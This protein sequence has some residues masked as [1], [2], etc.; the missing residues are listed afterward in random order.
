MKKIILAIGLAFSLSLS[1]Q[2]VDV[3]KDNILVDGSPVAKIENTKGIVKVSD[4][5]GKYLFSAERATSTLNKK[6]GDIA[7]W[8]R[9]TGANGNVREV[10]FSDT[11]FTLSNE[12]MITRNLATGNTAFLT[13]SG[14]NN[15]LINDYF[16][17]NEPSIS[18]AIEAQYK[19]IEE[20]QKAEDDKAQKA[21]LS[22]NDKGVIS[23][24]G[25]KAGLIN[26]SIK[27]SNGPVDPEYYTY[28]ATDVNGVV[29]AKL[30]GDALR[31]KSLLKAKSLTTYDGKT[32]DIHAIYSTAPAD[33][34]KVAERIVKALYSNGYNFGD[35]KE[36]VS[37][38]INQAN[39]DTYNNAEK[40]TVNLVNTDGYVTD[41]VGNKISGL[42]SIPFEN[43]AEKIKPNSGMS[44]ITNFGGFVKVK[45]TDGKEKSYKAK[46]GYTVFAGN[47]IFIPAKG[48]NDDALNSS[49]GSQL[50]L[51][52]EY[53]YFEKDYE[54][55][56]G[57]I[58]HH[59]K[60]P[61]YFYIKLK[62]SDI[63]SY[64]GEKGVFKNKP[65]EKMEKAFNETLKCSAM[66]FSDY[67]TNSK[68]GM[69]KVLE[70]YAAKCK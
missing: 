43:V 59:V 38:T 46:D 68:E 1:A 39:A 2:K 30:K 36:T 54:N 10:E 3:K 17:K 60:S 15:A 11:G 21:G 23:I 26:L 42:V 8:L 34:N 44:D 19:T 37:Q 31:G 22:I 27:K 49:S 40:N 12:K 61:N 7:Y 32:L 5:N 16:A 45:S 13:S 47:R 41:K 57:Y 50:S 56:A 58:V 65:A 64:L 53:Q 48:A 9:L 29:I 6:T 62:K 20:T 25:K 14:I 69:I 51:L 63:A 35:M 55:A 66:K 24:N 33:Q 18:D 67:D 28:T 4:L 52:G 70:D